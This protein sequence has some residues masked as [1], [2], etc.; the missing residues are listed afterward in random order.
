MTSSYGRLTLPDDPDSPIILD[1]RDSALE[2]AVCTRAGIRQLSEVWCSAGTY[3]LIGGRDEHGRTRVYVGKA[4]RLRDRLKDHVTNKPWWNRAILLQSKSREGFTTADAAWLEGEVIQR[5]LG[6]ES[7]VLE[8]KSEPSDRSLSVHEVSWLN[9]VVDGLFR[10]FRL[11][12]YSELSEQINIP[13]A[14]LGVPD[15]WLVRAGT[16]GSLAESFHVANE[17]RVGFHNAYD[18]DLT[19]V[20]VDALRAKGGSANAIGQLLRFRDAINVGDYVLTP[21]PGSASYLV[22]RV[23]G[24][25]RYDHAAVDFRHVR[26]VAWLGTLQADVLTDDLRRSLGSLLTL[27]HPA[28]Q[29]QL[30]EVVKRL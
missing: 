15:V 3:L 18:D 23:S 7:V 13:D 6:W 9:G 17:I 29:T 14:P 10:V 21:L 11:L 5:L 8:N 30:R 28:D 20:S 26:D 22:S 4:S 25:Y 2:F 24:N 27:F 19:G 12:G 1:L 16:G